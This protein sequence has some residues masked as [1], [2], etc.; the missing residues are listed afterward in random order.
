MRWFVNLV[1]W[2]LILGTGLGVWMLL[3]EFV[4]TPLISG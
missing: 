1:E 4:I 3:D 2:T